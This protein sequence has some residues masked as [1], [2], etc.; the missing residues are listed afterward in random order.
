MGWLGA[1][2]FFCTIGHAAQ[3]EQ[4]QGCEWNGTGKPYYV[5]LYK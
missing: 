5:G 2:C 4:A 3:V 1:V